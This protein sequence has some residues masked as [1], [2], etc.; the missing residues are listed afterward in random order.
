MVISVSKRHGGS[1]PPPVGPCAAGSGPAAGPTHSVCFHIVLLLSMLG[2]GIALPGVFPAP[3][4]DLRTAV[5]AVRCQSVP[6]LMLPHVG[7]E[8]LYR[9]CIRGRTPGRAPGVPAC[10]VLGPGEGRVCC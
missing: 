7:R 1:G 4:G 6:G 5:R 2:L 3:V 9:N 8:L 10:S